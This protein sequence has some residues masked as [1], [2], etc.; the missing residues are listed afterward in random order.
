MF[1]AFP[2]RSLPRALAS[3]QFVQSITGRDPKNITDSMAYGRQ[4]LKRKFIGAGG[5]NKRSRG[6]AWRV[7]GKYSGKGVTTQHDEKNIYYKKTMPKYKKRRWR[8]FVK[9]VQ[10]VHEKELG[11]QRY[12]YNTALDTSQNSEQSTTF[13]TVPFQSVTA[14]HLYGGVKGAASSTDFNQGVNDMQDIMLRIPTEGLGGASANL[15]RNRVNGKIKFISAILDITFTADGTNQVPLEVDVYHI[16]YRKNWNNDLSS[17]P[18]GNSTYE[19]QMYQYVVSY[20]NKTTNQAAAVLDPNLRLSYRGVTPFEMSP[21][22]A[23]MGIKIL[24]KT[25]HFVAA[26]STFTTQIRDPKTHIVNQE[27]FNSGSGGAYIRNMTQTLL[28]I[29]KPT[30]FNAL[31]TFSY[32]LGSTRSY[33]VQQDDNILDYSTLMTFTPPPPPTG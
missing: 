13:G 30:Y 6:R 2:G 15:A 28:F 27:L 12:L 7:S 24:K 14:V 29:V 1:R 31:D 18:I 26:G 11:V 21:A 9:R 33:K 17:S 32:H 5:K 10:A 8:K 23:A 25:K 20:D 16:M 19:E 22:I 3:S 4:N